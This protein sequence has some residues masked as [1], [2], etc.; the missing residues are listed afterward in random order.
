MRFQGWG[1]CFVYS[2]PFVGYFFCW[3]TAFAL[4]VWLI[5][6]C[7]LLHENCLAVGRQPNV[8]LTCDQL[9]LMGVFCF[10]D[11][12]PSKGG[13]R[14]SCGVYLLNPC[15]LIFCIICLFALK[16]FKG[17]IP[18]FYCAFNKKT[19]K[20]SPK[21]TK[22]LNKLQIKAEFS[23]KGGE[24][25]IWEEHHWTES[26]W[27]LTMLWPQGLLLGTSLNWEGHCPLRVMSFRSPLGCQGIL[28]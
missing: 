19:N 12:S 2:V 13:G 16:N 15:P 27:R 28:T 20:Y 26:R 4:A 5:T 11:L 8:S 17:I 1:L 14:C 23:T 24:L 10:G 3:C 9:I 25:R 6:K 21:R 7:P 22:P 18:K